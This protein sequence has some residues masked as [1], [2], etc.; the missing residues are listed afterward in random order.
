MS[1]NGPLTRTVADAALMFQTMVGPDDRDPL[2]L[3][4]TGEDFSAAVQGEVRLK[5]LR[6]AWTPDLRMVPVEPVVQEICAG[7]VRVFADLGCHIEENSPDRRGAHELF[8]VLNANLRT[9]TVGL[10]RDL[11]AAQMDPLLVLAPLTGEGVVAARLGRQTARTR[12]TSVCG[13]SLDA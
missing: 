1:F 7:A 3:P 6:V 8:S 12:S 2:S 5:G 4:D 10:C 11:A 13:S 9:A